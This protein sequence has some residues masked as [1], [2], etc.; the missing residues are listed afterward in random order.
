MEENILKEKSMALAVRM[1]NLY[2]YLTEEKRN[3]Y[4]L[5]KSYAVAPLLGLWYMNQS[6]L[7]APQ[8]LSISLLLLKKK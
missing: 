8:I 5:S 1:V 4:F 3:M 7:K 2:K 6:I